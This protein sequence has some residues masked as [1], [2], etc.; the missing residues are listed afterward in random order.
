[1][2]T[3]ALTTAFQ[4]SQTHLQK[5]TTI[6]LP[7]PTDHIWVTTDASTRA[8]GLSATYYVTRDTS[9]TK[10]L[11]GFFNARLRKAYEAWLPCELEALCITAAIRY[12]APYLIQSKHQ[13][14]V[15]TDSK[16]CV[17]AIGR[18]ERGKFSTSPRV[19]TYLSTVARYQVIVQYLPGSQNTISYFGSRNPTP[20]TQNKCQICSFITNTALSAVQQITVQDPAIIGAATTQLPTSV[21]DI[22]EGRLPLPYTNRPVWRSIQQECTD[23]RWTHSLLKAGIGPGKKA[24]QQGDVKRYHRITNVASDGM[25]VVTKHPAFHPKIECIIVLQH[26]LPGLL[27]ALHIKLEHATQRQLTKMFSRHFNALRLDDAV[28]T[29]TD[30]CHTCATLHHLPKALIPQSTSE[31]PEVVGTMFA[32]DVLKQ[33]R[34]RILVVRE[35]ITSLTVAAFVINETAHVL[36]EMLLHLI[37]RF[38]HL[39]GPQR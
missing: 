28:K 20:C 35:N 36:Q 18:L 30:T 13:P 39:H 34:Q 14:I 21:Q 12:F 11:A 9:T 33:R 26:V 32:T 25:L 4:E 10:L 3:D 15:L 5:A 2:W 16:A 27:T 31:P 8:Q 24:T 38:R 23:L 19:T 29:I 6:T 7:R 1:M 17:Q 37:L 22:Y